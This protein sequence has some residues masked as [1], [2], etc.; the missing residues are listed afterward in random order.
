VRHGGHVTITSVAAAAGVSKATVSR[1]MN[2]AS[3]VDPEIARRVQQTAE[4]LGYRPSATA[5]NL[6]RGRTGV[7][8]VLVP[9]LA[10]PV[11][12]MMLKGIEPQAQA[13]GFHV[14]VADAHEDPDSEPERAAELARQCDGLILCGP[15]MTDGALGG[16]AR[17]E[18]PIVVVNRRT[19][20]RTFP[21]IWID[22]RG[23]LGEL[24]RHLDAYGHRRVVYLAGPEQ[25]VADADRWDV[26]RR[27][28]RVRFERVQAG[29]TMAEGYD[30][31][32][33]VLGTDA[34]CVVGYNDLVAL[35]AMNRLREAG[36]AVPEQVSVAGIDDMMFARY[37]SPPLTTITVP[38]IEAGREAWQLLSPYLDG[39]KA[40]PSRTLLGTFQPRGSTG[41][42]TPAARPGGGPR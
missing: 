32:D 26:L 38:Q 40:R 33:A 36:L 12:T 16:L 24:C 31:A 34:S 8:G 18:R 30:A 1:V 15:R 2:G 39:R 10:N 22:L 23:A 29:A 7:V 3:T 20:G 4:R 6:S 5:Q 11:F 35:G 28:R 14:L 37:L 21:A 13:E 42:A 27:A 17:L 19:T 9:D 25:S 41:P